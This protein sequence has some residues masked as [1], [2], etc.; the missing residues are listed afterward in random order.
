M[1]I[2]TFAL[3]LGLAC[4]SAVAKAA[5]SSSGCGPGWYILKDNSLV[6]SSLRATTNGLLSPVYTG[7]MTTGTSNCTKHSIVQTEQQ[8]LYFVTQNLPTLK[9]E[10]AMAV[11]EHLSALAL[12]IGCRH[13]TQTHFNRALQKNHQTIFKSQNPSEVLVEIYKTILSNDQLTN[14]CSLHLS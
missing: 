8:S 11:G 5:D 14:Q 13:D 1:K 9:N 10:G 6:S 3:I 12:T 7:G 2:Q 4:L